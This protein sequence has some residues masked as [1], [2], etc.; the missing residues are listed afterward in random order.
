MN[1]YRQEEAFDKMKYLAV[2]GSLNVLMLLSPVDFVTTKETFSQ[3][4][5]RNWRSGSYRKTIRYTEMF[6]L[7]H[8]MRLK[9]RQVYLVN[10]Q[11]NEC[12]CLVSHTLQLTQVT[13][14]FLI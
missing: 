8:T 12:M 5:D 2:E 13:K 6:D 4:L 14:K 1:V 11:G 7:G 10:D 9:E 3:R